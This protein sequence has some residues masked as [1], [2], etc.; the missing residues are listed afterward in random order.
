MFNVTVPPLSE[1]MFEELDRADSAEHEKE[2][3]ERIF[4]DDIDRDHDP[5]FEMPELEEASDEE[6]DPA[7]YYGAFEKLPRKTSTPSTTT[8]KAG[9]STG[10]PTTPKSPFRVPNAPPPPTKKRLRTESEPTATNIPPKVL[11]PA[12]LTLLEGAR[13]TSPVYAFFKVDDT[14][15][16]HSV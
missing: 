5:D 3:D 16:T 15:K 2:M 6:D 12:S 7:E 8:P 1:S 9:T 14:Y 13:T 10:G 11:F 4:S